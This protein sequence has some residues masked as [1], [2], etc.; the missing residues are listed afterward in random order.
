[1]TSPEVQRNNFHFGCTLARVA[2][3]KPHQVLSLRRRRYSNHPLAHPT[4]RSRDCATWCC[5]DTPEMKKKARYLVDTGPLGFR[6]SRAVRQAL[7]PGVRQ[8]SYVVHRLAV[9]FTVA[10]WRRL[11]GLPRMVDGLNDG[12]GICAEAANAQPRTSHLVG[13]CVAMVAV[14]FTEIQ[15]LKIFTLLKFALLELPDLLHCQ[16]GDF[17]SCWQQRICDG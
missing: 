7:P 3:M 6:D 5:K 2:G 9:D 10:I 12:C 16:R 14:V 17:G 15:P 8:S 1:M 13:R 11:P 4:H